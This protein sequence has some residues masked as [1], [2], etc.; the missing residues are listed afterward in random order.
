MSERTAQA[1]QNSASKLPMSP[2][3]M[4]NG[5]PSSLRKSGRTSASTTPVKNIGAP[6]RAPRTPMSLRKAV[7]TTPLK[8]LELTGLVAFERSFL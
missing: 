4:S 5:S 6:S 1:L 7:L 8:G 3:A 2:L